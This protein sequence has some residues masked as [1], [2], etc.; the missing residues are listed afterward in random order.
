ML[1]VSVVTLCYFFEIVTYREKLYVI[2]WIQRM[3]LVWKIFIWLCMQGKR[4]QIRI[5][6]LTLE[7]KYHN[8]IF[9]II[10]ENLITFSISALKIKLKI[11][12]YVKLSKYI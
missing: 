4:F 5:S 8:V 9:S 10:V 12:I 7:K 3:N 11:S 2:Q 6:K 1:L